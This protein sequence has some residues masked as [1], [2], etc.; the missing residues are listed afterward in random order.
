LTRAAFNSAFSRLLGENAGLLLALLATD[1]ELTEKELLATLGGL[2]LA[3]ALLGGRHQLGLLNRRPPAYKPSSKLQDNLDAQS[4]LASGLALERRTTLLAAATAEKPANFEPYAQTVADYNLR[5][6]AQ[7]AMSDVAERVQ[8]GDIKL[9]GFKGKAGELE[10]IWR[11]VFPRPEPRGWHDTL[12]GTAPKA[13]G[14]WTLKSP[15]HGTLEVER[16]FDPKTPWDEWVK[17]GHGVEW[18]RA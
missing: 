15:R 6:G 9:R 7:A 13:D 11:R 1:G 8:S 17:C 2:L 16:P 4:K 14:K 18:R 10:P 3:G 12:N 5:F